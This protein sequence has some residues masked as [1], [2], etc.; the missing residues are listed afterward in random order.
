MPDCDRCGR[1]IHPAV[2]MM[3]GEGICP[4]CDGDDHEYVCESCEQVVR[5][6]EVADHRDQHD[7]TAITFTLKEQS[8]TAGGG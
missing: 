3:V 1:F 2:E 8:G 4:H 6:S 7:E 5:A